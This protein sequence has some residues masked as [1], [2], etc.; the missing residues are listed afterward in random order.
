MIEV[1]NRFTRLVVEGRLGLEGNHSAWKCRCDCGQ[2]VTAR[3]DKL[4]GGRVKSCGCL[5]DEI[6]ADAHA[7]KVAAELPDWEK[8]KTEIAACLRELRRA[9]VVAERLA[10]KSIATRLREEPGAG[11][12]KAEGLP[13]EEIRHFHQEGNPG[14]VAVAFK[15]W[16][17][18]ML[19]ILRV[20]P[21]KDQI[22]LDVNF[23]RKPNPSDDGLK[24]TNE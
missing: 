23:Y 20:G 6:S 14:S 7:K 21:D 4:L 18:V 15:S 12:S 3:G 13:A 9:L 17:E 8:Q 24:E 11:F 2:E 5:R 10:S 19:E 16:A 1:G 22:S